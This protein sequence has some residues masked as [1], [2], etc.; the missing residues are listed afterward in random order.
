MNEWHSKIPQGNHEWSDF[1]VSCAMNTHFMR[2]D[3]WKRNKVHHQTYDVSRTS[4]SNKIV[5]HSD[6]VGASPI[7]AYETKNI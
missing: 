4:V 2:A 3:E 7:G 6:V 5:D 1:E